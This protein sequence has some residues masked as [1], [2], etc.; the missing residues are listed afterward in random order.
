VTDFGRLLAALVSSEVDFIIIGGF[1]ATAHGSAF[2]TVDLD[3][4]YDRA[5]ANVRRLVAALEPLSPYLRGAPPGLPFRLDAATV[6]QGLNFTLR[7]AAGDLDLIGEA[8]GGG[9]FEALLPHTVIRDVL[10][11]SCRFVNLETLIRL[12][13]AA[14]R[15][16]DFERIAELESLRAER[17]ASD[18]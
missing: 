15:P 12:K 18:S 4:V 16:K 11:Y 9:T 10:G 6:A 14:G 5:P 2:L 17:D 3:V 1:A 13:R 7:T 8:T